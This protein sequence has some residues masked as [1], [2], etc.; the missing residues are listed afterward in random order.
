MET[1][2]VRFVTKE[3]IDEMLSKGELIIKREVPKIGKLVCPVDDTEQC[4]LIMG[5]MSDEILGKE[6]KLVFSR[7]YG[8]WRTGMWAIPDW[9]L[10]MSEE[11][12]E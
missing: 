8:C 4:G 3:K 1:K 11:V 2:T 9:L 6:L 7:T 5:L 12:K 10:K